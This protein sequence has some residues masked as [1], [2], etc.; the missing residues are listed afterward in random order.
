M[1]RLDSI[2]R[3]LIAAGVVALYFFNVIEGARSPT[4]YWLLLQ[5]FWLPVL[6]AFVRCIQFWEFALVRCQNP[7]SEQKRDNM[8]NIYFLEIVK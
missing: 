4:F 3:F 6:Q 7:I 5:F 8:I 1:G 2:I